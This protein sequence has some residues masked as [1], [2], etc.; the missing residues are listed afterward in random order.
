MIIGHI[1]VAFAAKRRWPRIS[2]G[3]LLAA[4]FAPDL[5]RAP[6]VALGYAWQQT[7]FY[8]HALPWCLAIAV[9]A[10]A[11]AW[12]T[13]HDRT[14]GLVV[15]ALVLSHIAL[16]MISGN[17]ALWSGGPTGID[18]GTFEQLELVVESG[19]VL[20]GWYLLRRLKQPRWVTHWSL[21]VA[22]IVLQTVSLL[23]SVSRRPY[24][25]R[26]LAYPIGAC[27]DASWLT[28]RWDT[29]PFW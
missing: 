22:L 7:N 26:C 10:G 18:L 11:L 13:L 2:L 29:T 25:T 5:L 19:L 17:K 20:A 27:T 28:Q 15:F 8:T 3:A 4:S 6:F 12:T 21:P 1:G 23:A 16:D 24:A 9:G 14:A